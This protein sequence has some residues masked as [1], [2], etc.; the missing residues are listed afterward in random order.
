M[1][2][3]RPAVMI[4]PAPGD[5]GRRESLSFFN[6]GRHLFSCGIPVPEIY[7]FSTRE[8]TLIVEDLGNT[9]LYGLVNRPCTEDELINIYTKTISVLADMQIISLDGFDTAWCF[10]STHF[11]ADFAL[12]RE[13]KYFLEYLVKGLFNLEITSDLIREIE[14]F[15]QMMN[16][17]DMISG[18]IHRDFQSRNIMIQPE[19]GCKIRIIDFQGARL[20]PIVY[21]LVSLLLDPYAIISDKISCDLKSIYVSCLRK[22]GINVSRHD[23]DLQFNMLGVSRLMQAL[24]AFAKLGKLYNKVWFFQHIPSAIERLFSC[25]ALDEFSELIH[26]KSLISHLRHT[27]SSETTGLDFNIYA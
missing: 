21:D 2:R 10:E 6:I 12:E 24:G 8:G 4:F 1:F 5:T 3:A 14:I 20:G 9:S 23:F 22:H 25:L 16:D 13:G 26:L 27:V 15:Y 17:M 7:D 18:L 11:T 19:N